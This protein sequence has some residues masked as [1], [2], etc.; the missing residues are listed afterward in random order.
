MR[1][2]QHV[3]FS[4]HALFSAMARMLWDAG[5]GTSCLGVHVLACVHAKVCE[6]DAVKK[7]GWRGIGRTKRKMT[8][9][10]K[11][12]RYKFWRRFVWS[13]SRVN[14]IVVLHRTS[15]SDRRERVRFL[16]G[17][18]PSEAW[19]NCVIQRKLCDQSQWS[20]G[21]FQIL[22][23]FDKSKSWDTAV[24]CVLSNQWCHQSRYSYEPKQIQVIMN[25]AKS[26]QKY[27]AWNKS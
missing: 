2:F 27:R 24:C 9:R 11:K 4:E 10:V 14:S 23:R 16:T 5:P 12:P 18:S 8:Y 15:K 25:K 21:N 6:R 13:K 7:T 26:K 17:K 3:L 19:K 1:A 22:A 20:H